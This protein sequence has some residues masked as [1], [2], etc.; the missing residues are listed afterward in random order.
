[1]ANRYN[2]GTVISFEFIRTIKKP[3]FWAAT[4]TTP[5][6]LV[7]LFTVM[8]YSNKQAAD[9]AK[10]LAEKQFSII[11]QDESNTILP[12]IA[13]GL[14]AK[15]A[16][17]KNQA[18]AD[19]KAGKYDAFFYYPE[20]LAK[21]TVEVHGKDSGLFE[22][23]KYESVAKQLLT[24]SANAKVNNESTAAAI[25]G[26]VTTK[27]TAYKENG[28]VAAGWLA[29]APPL[30]FLVLFY[31]SV[32]MLGNNLLSS[33]VEEKENR[34]TEMILTTINPSNL[35]IGKMIATFLAGAVQALVIIMP[36]IVAYFILGSKASTSGLPDISLLQGIVIEPTAMIIGA[37]L[38]IG[39]VL[40]F[41]GSLM[42]I[43]A[44]M[45]T[46]KEAG[47]WFGVVI[48]AMFL[49]FYLISLILSSPESSIVQFLTYLPLTAPIT[50]MLRNAFGSLDLLQAS[51]VI[52]LL[53][54]IG[55]IVTRL[56]VH[57]FRYGA[58]QYDSK[59]SLKGL[60]RR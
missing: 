45:P 41:S 55:V 36:V 46:A 11:Y 24:L 19:V 51:I 3:S 21:A 32:I 27:L 9:T 54:I 13:N 42:T 29:A 49:P 1:M 23:G 15:Q 5:V 6:L 57:L 43:G 16:S 40:L 59:L 2:L 8:F 28:E 47:Q 33:T 50:A 4:L 7:G 39:G 52:A 53:L 30:L 17:D 31:L 25:K 44:I 35:I 34:V 20:N 37:L 14:Q 60:F 58:M 56:A 26:S 10:K 48:L 18:I 22:N 12:Q 38:F